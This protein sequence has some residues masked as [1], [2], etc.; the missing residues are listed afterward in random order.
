[1]LNIL[2]S[3]F[4][5]LRKNKTTWICLAVLVG[6]TL[7]DASIALLASR[8]MSL[9]DFGGFDL[10]SMDGFIPAPVASGALTLFGSDTFIAAAILVSIVAGRFYAGENNSGVLRNSLMAGQSRTV[11]YSA[12]FIMTLAVSAVAY[13]I[14]VLVCMAMYGISGGFGDVAPGVFFGYMALQLLL[15]LSIGALVFLL[16]IATRSVGGSLGI[17]IGA[18]F[19]FII[20][21]SL[22]TAGL[23][24]SAVKFVDGAPVFGEPHLFFK[25]LMEICRLLS[26]SQISFVSSMDLSPP[27]VVQAV[28]V[29]AVTLGAAYGGGSAIFNLRDHK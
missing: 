22:A 18:C 9:E 4:F 3:E 19:F 12:K 15:F 28:L 14:P 16:S 10:S 17:T 25:A 5:K 23:E 24:L 1:M 8:F 20:L 11:V 7:F 2:K 29:G 21:S 26:P 6:Y 27:R 13:L